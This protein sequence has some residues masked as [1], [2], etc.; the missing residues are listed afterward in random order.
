MSKRSFS[1][2]LSR[3][4]FLGFFALGGGGRDITLRST[5]L[6]DGFWRQVGGLVGEGVVRREERHG[7]H[8]GREFER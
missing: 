5:L 8:E 4:S 3:L 7:G 2:R 1:A 6:S